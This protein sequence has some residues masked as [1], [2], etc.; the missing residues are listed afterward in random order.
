MGRVNA[1][2]KKRREKDPSFGLD[3]RPKENG[4]QSPIVSSPA[5]QTDVPIITTTAPITEPSA[6]PSTAT[7]PALPPRTSSSGPKIPERTSSSGFSLKPSSLFAPFLS[8]IDS[9]TPSSNPPLKRQSSTDAAN[10][11]F[12]QVETEFADLGRELAYSKAIIAAEMAGWQEERVKNGV[13]NMETYVAETVVV[14]KERLAAGGRVMRLVGK[15]F[16]V[17]LVKG[18]AG[19][20]KKKRKRK[21]EGK[22]TKT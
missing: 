21:S 20:T 16:D 3:S 5:N 15:D 9:A 18:N 10:A 1:S 11:K 19:K 6:T 12:R 14:E 17:N 13:E 7:A 8:I 4:T 2:I 22:K